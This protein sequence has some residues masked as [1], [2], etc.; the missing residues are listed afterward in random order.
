MVF[1]DVIGA[2]ARSVVLLDQLEPGLEQIGERNAVVVE[3]V[4]NAEL[5]SHGAASPMIFCRW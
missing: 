3:M 2:K 5:Q 1:G 4:E